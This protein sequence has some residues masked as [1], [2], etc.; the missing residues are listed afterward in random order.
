[1]LTS[2]HFRTDAIKMTSISVGWFWGASLSLMQQRYRRGANIT[3]NIIQH[4]EFDGN[5]Q[6]DCRPFVLLPWSHSRKCAGWLVAPK[7]FS[8][9]QLRRH[10]LCYLGV[11]YAQVSVSQY[12][13]VGPCESLA[14]STNG[15]K[16]AEM[17]LKFS[18][19]C[20]LS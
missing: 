10:T 20:L 6:C 8:L 13:L 1:M 4:G 9:A 14:Y 7:S 2:L 18:H 12:K 19:F 16:T 11:R 15:S 3:L 17:N 5:V